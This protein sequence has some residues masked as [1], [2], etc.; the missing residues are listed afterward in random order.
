MCQGTLF[1][2][3]QRYTSRSLN[4]IFGFL[5]EKIGILLN[6]MSLSFKGN[7]VPLHNIVLVLCDEGAGL[8]AEMLI[9]Q[10]LSLKSVDEEVK[11]Y[12]GQ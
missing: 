7:R 9:C 12:L 8:V 4:S 1:Q 6:L 10:Q 3:C 11:S 5:L 2:I